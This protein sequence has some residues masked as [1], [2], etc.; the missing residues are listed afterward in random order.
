MTTKSSISVNAP[1]TGARPRRGSFVLRMVEAEA[2]T[3]PGSSVPGAKLHP[4]FSRSRH[5]RQPWDSSRRSLRTIRAGH[6]ARPLAGSCTVRGPPEKRPWTDLPRTGPAP[7]PR[8]AQRTSKHTP[9]GHG[10]PTQSPWPGK[11]DKKTPRLCRAAT[12]PLNMF[13]NMLGRPRCFRLPSRRKACR[14]QLG[15]GLGPSMV[16]TVQG[17]CCGSRARQGKSEFARLRPLAKSRGGF[18][19]AFRL[20][21]RPDL[22]PAQVKNAGSAKK[23]QSLP[24]WLAG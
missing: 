15:C 22:P 11:S 13:C 14:P 9:P 7:V 23:P 19:T 24:T 2:C 4:T 16:S 10:C 3:A 17:L 5:T 1:E 6:E 12:L 20:T 18:S 21:Y 8:S